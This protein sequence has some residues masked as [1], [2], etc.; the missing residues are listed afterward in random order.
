MTIQLGGDK[1]TYYLALATTLRIHKKRD[2]MLT[3]TLLK[4]MNTVSRILFWTMDTPGY[5]V[6]LKVS[7]EYNYYVI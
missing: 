2:S 7:Q 3:V 6:I 1:G 4:I 5:S